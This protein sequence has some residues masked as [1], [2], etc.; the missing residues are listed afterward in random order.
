[1]KTLI[2]AAGVIT[3]LFLCSFNNP[4]SSVFTLD[5]GENLNVD[6]TDQKN[7]ADAVIP[8]IKGYPEL[9]PEENL[10]RCYILNNQVCIAIY[11]EPTET[12][13]GSYGVPDGNGGETML[14]GTLRKIGSSGDVDVYEVKP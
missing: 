13:P 5:R 9:V 3:F 6:V 14:Y 7:S 1:M 2:S 12:T 11:S 10:I 4:A 8:Y